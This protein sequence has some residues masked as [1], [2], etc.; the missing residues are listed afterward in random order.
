MQ[1]LQ[2]C[3]KCLQKKPLTTDF[4]NKLSTGYWRGTCKSCM[5]ANTRRHYQ[6]NPEKSAARAKK[7]HD[8]KALAGGSYNNHDIIKIRMRLNDRCRYCGKPLNG[9]GEIDHWLP[10]SRGGDSSP[11]NLTIA[12][13]TCNRDKHSKTGDE[14]IDWR[15][16]LNLPLPNDKYP[17]KPPLC[18]RKS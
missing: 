13:R 7:Y 18:R 8:Q 6:A 17:S 5:A 14:F 3:K 4:F 11:K 2:V 1:R 15:R 16:R 10:I 12:C 9:G